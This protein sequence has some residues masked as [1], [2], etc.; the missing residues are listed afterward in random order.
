MEDRL[1]P[2]NAVLGLVTP[3]DVNPATLFDLGYKAVGLE[4]PVVG[5]HG[6]VVVDVVLFNAQ[7]LHLVLVE[8]KSGANVD[9]LQAA[10]YG[11]LD[12]KEVVQ[13]TG[14]TLPRRGE[15]SVDVAY[16]C[17]AANAD[18]IRIGLDRAKL[19]CAVMS[20]AD[21]SIDLINAEASSKLG[22]AWSEGPVAL[23]G[24]VSRLL[25]FDHETPAADLR[26]FVYAE[27]VSALSNRARE[28][29]VRA[30]TERTT[31]YFPLFSTGAQRRLVANVRAAVRTI[32]EDTPEAFAYV[33]S[34]GTR[35]DDLVSLLKTP[36]DR[37]PRG[38]TQAY[39]ALRDRGAQRRRQ[40]VSEHQLDLLDLLAEAGRAE[41]VGGESEDVLAEEEST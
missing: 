15:V 40:Q 6:R 39:Q 10:R 3:G 24:P 25:P 37:D 34:T 26:P 12:P 5:P 31:P 23:V 4:V 33:P 29:T 8:A 2:V 27:L 32:A 36:E 13:A 20:V 41:T 21:R 16:A 38:R 7:L 11:A 14:V 19:F 35:I 9:E 30:L 1:R 22:S 17:L 28:I 18:R